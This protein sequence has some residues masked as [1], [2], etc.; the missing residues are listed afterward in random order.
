MPPNPFVKF[1]V[2]CNRQAGGP[3]PRTHTRKELLVIT[4]LRSFNGPRFFSCLECKSLMMETLQASKAGLSRATDCSYALHATLVSVTGTTGSCWCGRQN[5][6][7]DNAETRFRF[8]PFYVNF[9][10]WTLKTILHIFHATYIIFY[11][12]WMHN[13][14][15]ILLSY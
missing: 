10:R 5:C 7:Y 3:Q 8:W 2:M 1:L 12:N 6:V 15:T 13:N 4:T 14:N 11:S 9:F